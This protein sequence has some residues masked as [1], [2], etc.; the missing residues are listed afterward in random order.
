MTSRA[1]C[2]RCGKLIQVD[3]KGEAGVAICEACL[4]EQVPHDTGPCDDPERIPLALFPREGSDK[5]VTRSMLLPIPGMQPRPRDEMVCRLHPVNFCW[6]EI[7]DGLLEFIGHPSTLLVQQTFT[8]YVHQDDRDLAEEEFR[9][10]CEFGERHDL[11]IR[12]KSRAGQ[13]HYMRISTQARYELNGR[14]NHLRCNLRDVTDGVRAE[15]EL[16]RRTEKLIAANLQLRQTNI[17]LKLTQ[18]QLV[19]S[20]KLAALGT[21]TAG[22]AHEINN[23]LAFAVNNLAVLERD[24][25]QLLNI[26]ALHEQLAH[27][28]ADARPDLA[29]ALA[30]A[31]DEADPAYLA[32]NVPRILHST[33][34]GLTRIAQIVDKLRGF[35]RVDRAEIG[36]F[37]VNESIDQCLIMLNATTT[38][39]RINVERQFGELPSFHGAVADL[40]QAFLDLLANSA[41][42]IE[43]AGRA[44]GRI[45]VATRRQ[46]E[47]IVVEICDNGCGISPEVIPKIFDPFF[48]TKPL[49][50]GM[51]LGLSV[52]HGII[53][54]HGGHIEVTSEPEQGS[55]FRAFL[56]VGPV[57]AKPHA[58]PDA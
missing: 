36:P 3:Q 38:R 51:G 12:L 53:T 25:S 50:Q 44:S 15:H 57:L 22:M 10:T 30:R 2:L 16:R 26:L 43:A 5:V 29:A 49:G 9:Q 20:E 31:R 33:Y 28:H 37:D 39:L 46:A 47:E 52:S 8:Q 54:R 40:N 42:A 11:V 17:E 32:E 1:P 56:P 23:P 45:V 18:A 58:G 27:D 4:G 19:H 41:A 24:F 48:T 13:W 55:C 7:S 6:L 35:S 34:K 21:L 14:V